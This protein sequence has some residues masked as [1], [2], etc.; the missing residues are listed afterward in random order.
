MGGHAAFLPAKRSLQAFSE[1]GTG[2]TAIPGP[3]KRWSVAVS[4]LM[5]SS[6]LPAAKTF[7]GHS[8]S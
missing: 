2:E 5:H 6:F 7:K 3:R 8:H 1:K 4:S